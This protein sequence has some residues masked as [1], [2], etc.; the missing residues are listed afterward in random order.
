MRHRR[1]NRCKF[2]TI[3]KGGWCVLRWSPGNEHEYTVSFAEFPAIVEE[4]A[5]MKAGGCPCYDLGCRSKKVYSGIIDP[6]HPTH[7]ESSVRKSF[8]VQGHRLTALMAVIHLALPQ[9]DKNAGLAKWRKLLD[10]VKATD[11]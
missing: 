11:N 8:N 2:S 3:R 1:A 7:S 10:D 4:R 5:E 6:S 9:L